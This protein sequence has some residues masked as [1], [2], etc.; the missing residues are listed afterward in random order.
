M[1]APEWGT[2]NL[3]VAYGSR[4]AL[5]D[6]TL[7]V[8]AGAVTAVVGGDGAGKTTLLRAMVGAVS[9]QAGIVQR[10]APKRIGYVAGNVGVYVDLTVTENLAFAGGAYGLRGD[11][12]L[13]RA[14]ALIAAINL[15][16]AES[17]LAGHLSGG[18]R[19][20]LA[21][22]MAVIHEPELL[23]LDE[24]TTGVDP[25]S[26]AELWRLIAGAAAGGAAVLFAT[27]YLDEAERAASVLVLNAGRALLSGSPE[28][29]VA[30]IPGK[31]WT[32]PA[33]RRQTSALLPGAEVATI[34]SGRPTARSPRRRRPCSPI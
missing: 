17:R 29:I 14:T 28:Q 27:T 22:A 1:S 34:A 33:A 32:L 10:P 3:V 24:P 5:D 30:T 31:L 6:V 23:V 21:F 16:G 12:L 15:K 18:M 25:L 11:A 4:L 20:K 8:P 9:A 13:R 2:T 19:Q 7:R 26:R